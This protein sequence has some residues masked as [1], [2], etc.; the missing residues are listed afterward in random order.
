MNTEVCIK[1][2]EKYLAKSDVGVL[3]VDVQNSADLSDIVSHFKV[4][5]NTF[6]A[7]ADYCKTDEL[8]RMDM[9]RL[10]RIFFSQLLRSVM[11]DFGQTE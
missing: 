1:K 11:P 9:L 2:I 8:P 10:R 5:G 3:V 7:T 4:I 6:I